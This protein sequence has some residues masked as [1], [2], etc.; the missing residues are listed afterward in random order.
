MPE[1]HMSGRAELYVGGAIYG[2]WK[3]VAVSRTIEQIANGFDLEVTERWPGQSTSRPIRPGE[4]CLLKLDGETVITGHVDD[5]EPTYDHQSHGLSVR[6]RDATGDLVDCSAIHKTGQW[7]NATLD[8]I[9]RDLCAPFG[10]KVKVETDVGDSF[11]SFKIEPGETAFECVERAARLKAVLLIA[12]GDG[13]LVITR[14]GRE[15]SRTALAEGRNILSA[16]GQ[17]SW[18]D[19]FSIYTVKGHDRIALDGD[20]AP[21]HVA[22]AATAADEAIT[23][24]RPRIILADDHGNKTRFRDRAEWERNVRMGRGLRG[25]ITVQGWRD[26]QGK[27]WQ[28]NTLVTVTSPL[29]YLRD[30]QMLIVG[31][32][33]TLDESGT[34][35][36]LSI[37][38][39]EA[40]DL[41]SGI[42]RSK[43]FKKINAKEERERKQKADTDWSAL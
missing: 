34:R 30:A 4:R 7:K 8:R 42:G 20:A 13:N 14:A 1:A 17:F 24:Y 39:R 26:D 15:R 19:R 12:D 23:R 36:A 28:P 10:I 22:P 38:R 27:L 6:G 25:S 33:Y 18:R 21:G 40:F 3:R 5:S 16:R 43:L 31:C 41:I 29:L 32:L 9:A 37:A 35:T 2:G 11:A